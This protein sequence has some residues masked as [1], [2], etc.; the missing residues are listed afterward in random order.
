MLPKKET[1]PKDTEEELLRETGESNTYDS[2][3]GYK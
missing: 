1:F 2:Y 3:D